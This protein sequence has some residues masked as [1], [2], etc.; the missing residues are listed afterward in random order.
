[1]KYILC[2]ILLC[3][4]L[5][6]NICA[7]SAWGAKSKSLNV[8][9]CRSDLLKKEE[10]VQVQTEEKDEEAYPNMELGCNLAIQSRKEKRFFRQG[11]VLVRRIRPGDVKSHAS[12]SQTARWV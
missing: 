2:I 8:Q 5:I 10:D 1:M 12:T 11:E 7:A 4:S 3:L 9:V 6:R